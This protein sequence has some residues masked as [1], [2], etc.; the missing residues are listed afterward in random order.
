[1]IYNRKEKISVLEDYTA[2]DF[3]D[4]CA[5]EWQE[6]GMPL[7]TIFHLL[8]HATTTVTEKCY[9]K[10]RDGALH[11]ARQ[12]MEKNTPD[13]AENVADEKTRKPL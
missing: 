2:H 3:R 4:T 12:W 7:A 1:M 5:T 11:Q 6:A 13:A 10:F 8:G 9:I